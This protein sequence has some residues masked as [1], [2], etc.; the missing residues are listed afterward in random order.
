MI[1]RFEKQIRIAKK[2]IDVIGNIVEMPLK[3][4][5]KLIKKCPQRMKI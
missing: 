3:K 5:P 4:F 1:N 2:G